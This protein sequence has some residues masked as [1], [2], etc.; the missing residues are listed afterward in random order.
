VRLIR[1]LPLP[2]LV[3]TLT[4]FLSSCATS[5]STDPTINAS[6]SNILVI[7]VAN[8]YDGRARFERRTVSGLKAEGI[9]ATPMYT[10]GGGNKPI[11]RA[12]IE[13]LVST[14]GYDAVL[15]S[16]VLSREGESSVKTGSTATKATRREGRAVDLF[17]YDYEE[18]NE[19]MILNTTLSVTI[20]TELFAAANSQKVWSIESSISRK[21]SLDEL[22]NEASETI[23]RR[24][25]KD[26]LIGN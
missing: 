26:K 24:L 8:D 11:D 22:I 21:D 23:V 5:T 6:F 9:N 20:S 13:E 14:N 3:T 2:L 4:V 18:L 10:V 25:R 7:G 15:I 12:L 17:R 16:R 19:P 1:N